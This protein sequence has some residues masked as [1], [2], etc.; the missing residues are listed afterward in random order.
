MKEIVDEILTDTLYTILLGLDGEANI[1]RTQMSY[2]IYN[3][4]G[5]LISPDGN[6]ETEAWKQFHEE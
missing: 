1:G 3:E 2:K 4:E 5:T 6:I